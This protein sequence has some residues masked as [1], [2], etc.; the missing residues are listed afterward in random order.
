MIFFSEEGEKSD[1]SDTSEETMNIKRRNYCGG[2][3]REKVLFI[4]F[5]PLSICKCKVLNH[6]SVVVFGI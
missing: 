3:R 5:I 1:A 6:V 2:K 4:V